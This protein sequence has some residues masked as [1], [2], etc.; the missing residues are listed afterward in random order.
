MRKYV[1]ALFLLLT[2][3]FQAYSQYRTKSSGNWDV[4]SIWQI[5][6][7]GLWSDLPEGTHYPN[8]IATVTISSGDTVYIPNGTSI[9]ISGGGYFIGET[10]A[11][12][13]VE[14]TLNILSSTYGGFEE[15]LSKF[16]SIYISGILSTSDIFNVDTLIVESGGNL[17]C[18]FHLS[19]ATNNGWWYTTATPSLVS[20]RGTVK[21]GGP[22]GQLIPTFQDSSY[23]NI[24]V[25]GTGTK[26][27]INLGGTS[28]NIDGTLEIQ[29]GA[30]SIGDLSKVNVNNLVINTNGG[31]I[32]KSGSSYTGSLIISGNVSGS[33]YMD[34]ERYIPVDNNWHNIASPVNGPSLSI[35]A[36]SNTNIP[37]K[38]GPPVIYGMK[39]YNEAEGFWDTIDVNNIGNFSFSNGRGYMARIISG[40]TVTFQGLPN[41][42]TVT[43]PVGHERYG[44]NSVGNPYSSALYITS[45]DNDPSSFIYQ[46][47][48]VKQNLDPNRAAVFKWNVNG[49]EILSPSNT[50]SPQFIPP[51]QGFIIKADTMITS[52]AFEPSMQQHGSPG[53]VKKS[54]QPWKGF[55]LRI[56]GDSLSSSTLIE[57]RDDM[58][59]GLDISY[60][61]GTF[62]LSD[63]LSIYTRLVEDNNVDFM[64]QCLPDFEEVDLPIPVGVNSS[65]GGLVSFS[66]EVTGLPS[67][68]RLLLEDRLLGIY[69]NLETEGTEY[70]AQIDASQ[71][72]IGRF[73]LHT[74]GATNTEKFGIDD[75]LVIF[76]VDKEIVIEGNP[77]DKSIAELY[78]LSGTKLMNVLLQPSDNNRFNVSLN[79]G[80]YIIKI[81]GT[82]ITTTKKVFI[83]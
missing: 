14:G 4:D 62:A 48:I 52:I 21:F 12:L 15:Y 30:L 63:E 70:E 73:Y 81:T 72:G 6:Q 49:Y 35:F 37:T 40:S 59:Q 27:T 9:T 58:T 66:A 13:N 77:G 36:S 31:L 43:T 65:E 3:T 47:T 39:F 2:V 17:E 79:E 54:A 28:L 67:G 10:R 80:I 61:I 5:R 44:W 29:N 82:K 78:T 50:S 23:N 74:K 11:C 45:P 68:Y 57:F 26:K 7:Y 22:S 71:N 32:L 19:T 18:L 60:D 83:R 16:P 56:A 53:F 51:G 20:L 25:T 76:A 41:H 24:T 34:A 1:Y 8:N 69:T 38:A 55:R 33:G 42:G 75:D 46:N 64:I